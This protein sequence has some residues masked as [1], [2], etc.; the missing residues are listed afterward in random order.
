[1]SQTVKLKKTNDP[2]SEL[3]YLRMTTS[4]KLALNYQK[5]QLLAKNQR[6]YFVPFNFAEDEGGRK[7][8]A[9]LYYFTDELIYLE[10]YLQWGLSAKHINYLISQI[11]RMFTLCED[12]GFQAQNI[13][14]NIKYSFIYAESNLLKF[15]YLPVNGYKS[16]D[17]AL[18]DFLLALAETVVPEDYRAQCY[19]AKLLD[20][21]RR[22]EVF[23]LF[24]LKQF[25][26]PSDGN[27]AS[28]A[29]AVAKSAAKTA[30]SFK[31]SSHKGQK[32]DAP[33]E[34]YRD[35]VQEATGDK[36]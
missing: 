5:A 28:T 13:F 35:F 6:S 3:S 25:I 11:V 23:S 34:L 8:K 21:L 22:Q 20:F 14:L 18:L 17:C 30:A 1:M 4:K 27:N 29:R 19:Q 31:S 9:E 32:P 26:Q 10:D 15:I 7:G 2:T 24:K 12:Y 33:A 16:D 36:R